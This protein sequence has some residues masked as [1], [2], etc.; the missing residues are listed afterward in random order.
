MH[1]DR[2]GDA[3]PRAR[4]N[5]AMAQRRSATPSIPA[6]PVFVSRWH[7]WDSLPPNMR[8]PPGVNHTD[9]LHGPGFKYVEDFEWKSTN[10]CAANV[11]VYRGKTQGIFF[12]LQESRPNLGEEIVAQALLARLIPIELFGH[13]RL[14]LWPD[15]ERASHF[16]GEVMRPYTSAQ[17]DPAFGFRRRASSR[18]SMSR[19]SS[20]L[21]SKTSGE[22]AILF[23][24]SSTSWR[25]SRT[26]SSK[27]SAAENLPIR[28]RIS[29]CNCVF[30]FIISR[31]RAFGRPLN[32]FWQ[33]GVQ[34]LNVGG[35]GSRRFRRGR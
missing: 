2:T 20:S 8:I 18:S 1:V 21:N 12:N 26:G 4:S 22:S 25:R 7:L 29:P 34:R 35:P 17:D 19:L 28:L 23:Q 11:A 30:K 15:D 32:G 5:V 24:I 9:N 6:C 27:T 33:P 10:Q 16:L 13:I 31:Q 3:P 14:R